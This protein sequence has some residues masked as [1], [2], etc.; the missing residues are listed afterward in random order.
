[1][2]DL[3]NSNSPSETADAPSATEPPAGWARVLVSYRWPL[4]VVAVA[5]IAYLVY[6]ET[7]LQVDR[8]A[9][10]AGELAGAAA[11]TAENVARNLLTGDVTESFIAAIPEL[12]AGDSGNLELATAKATETFTRSDERRI[13]WDSISLGTTATEIRVPV[14]YRYHLRLTDPWR[15]EIA[16]S[17]CVVN[18]P[19]IRPSLPPA[20]HTDGMEKRAQA[21]WLRFDAEDQLEALER[22]ITPQL[23]GYAQDPRHLD[24]VREKS[25]RTVREFVRSWLLRE[26]QWSDERLHAVVVIFPD[27]LEDSPLEGLEIT[28][29]WEIGDEG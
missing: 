1:M 22:S 10:S 21:G 25:R 24:W 17:T 23:V 18:A 29:G 2:A 19:R 7:V 11:A 28:E 16:G 15:I 3:P 5:L 14:T 26:G 6:R 27:E 4:A 13:L 12:D 9:E 20:I 8:L